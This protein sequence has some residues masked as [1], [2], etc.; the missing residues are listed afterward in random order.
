MGYAY[1]FEKG[2][3]G[4]QRFDDIPYPTPKENE[5]VLK[6]EACGLCMSDPHLLLSGSPMHTGHDDVLPDKFIMGHEVAGQVY[7][8]GS[9]LEGS[10]LYPKGGRFALFL[11]LACGVCNNCR[12]GKDNACLTAGYAYGLNHDGGFQQYLR[13]TNLKTLLRIPEGVSYEQ[14]AVAS[15]SV[16][17]P[18]HA[19]HKA[20]E[21]LNPTA[22]VLVVGCGGLGL[23][24]IQIL[25]AYGVYVVAMDIKPELEKVARS[26]GADEYHTD[27][28]KSG[29]KIESFDACYDFVGNQ[30]STDACQLYVRAQGKIITVGLGRSKFFIKNYDLAR[31]EVEYIWS[32]GGTSREQIESMNWIAL[33]KIKPIVSVADFSEVEEYINK[34]VNGEIEG[35]VVFKPN[36]ESKSKL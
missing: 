29:H 36:V 11:P 3:L 18:F 34:L 17:T 14:A 10:K 5:L 6:V 28:S 20:K 35:R 22:R 12:V 19:I 15:D 27:L 1:G 23:N 26:L 9:A 30:P 4:L 2:K 8:V 21:F 31:R 33:G 13:I 32:F 16:L 24:G 7:E 25:K